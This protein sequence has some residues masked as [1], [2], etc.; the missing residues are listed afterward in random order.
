M[1]SSSNWTDACLNALNRSVE[2]KL[3]ALYVSGGI[4][5]SP[6][7][8]AFSLLSLPLPMTSLATAHWH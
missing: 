8:V 3:A 2:Q 1:L 5:V 4:T 6:F 7:E